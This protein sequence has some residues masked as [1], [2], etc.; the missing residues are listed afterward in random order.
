M[1]KDPATIIQ[2][3][4]AMAALG[5]YSGEN[6]EAEHAKEAQRLGGGMEY[7][8]LRMANALLGIVE[9]EAMHSETAGGAAEQ[10]LHAHNQALESAGA[11]RSKEMLLGFLRWR[12]L[13]VAGPLRQI[14]Q[15][16][17]TGPIP[18]AAAHAAEGLQ[19]LLGI[20]ADGQ[21]IDPDTMSPDAMK[22]NL[23]SAKD[24]LKQ[25]DRQR[26]HHAG[27]DRRGGRVFA[28]DLNILVFGNSDVVTIAQ[29]TEPGIQA[30]PWGTH[31]PFH[32]VP[33]R[34]RPDNPRARTAR[35]T[36]FSR[37]GKPGRLC[38]RATTPTETPDPTPTWLS[39]LESV[40]GRD[41]AFR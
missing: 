33:R 5:A 35:T 1:K 17:E 15:D 36:A 2:L 10:L 20:T 21:S 19:Q 18:L 39:T 3:A 40:L 27:S 37:H 26:R 6:T 22:E 31:P 29:C 34:D 13:R 28:V 23:R 25:C 16:T 7:Y 11:T 30:R 32:P 38:S 8:R 41:R 24:V 14:A 12:T 4:A 9:T